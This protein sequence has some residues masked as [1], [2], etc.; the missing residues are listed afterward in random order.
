VSK[1]LFK[2]HVQSKMKAEVMQD[3]L[4][5]VN[6]DPAYT[7]TLLDQRA[8]GKKLALITNSDWIYTNT[9][10]TATYEPYL[11]HGMAWA[12]LFDVV[13][14]SACKPEFF[15]TSRRPVYEIA[16]ADGFLREGF[17]FTPGS[18][19]AGGNAKNV[20]RCLGVSGPEAL[21]VGD[22]LFTDVNMAKRGLSWRTCLILQELEGEMAGLGDGRPA[23][24]RLTRLLRKKD[25]Q[26][27]Y[28]NH[29]RA[30][31]LRLTP[32][33]KSDTSVTFS[34]SVSTVG[35]H[36]ALVDTDG[37]V[38]GGE[39]AAVAT[40]ALAAAV[41]AG[42]SEG[43][44]LHA[45]RSSLLEALKALEAEVAESESEILR[46]VDVEGNHV[47]A[48][49][50]YMSRAG[51]ADKSH[52]MR[53]IEKYADIYTS[54]VSNL[55]PYSPYKQFLCQRQSLAHSTTSY[56]GRPLMEHWQISALSE[57][58]ATTTLEGNESHDDAHESHDA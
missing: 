11:P 24:Q 35:G 21:Y 10:M 40:T 5:F 45:E 36:G 39:E 8:A 30:R 3:P 31:L 42:E 41:T 50:G 33:A 15:S 28:V 44:S 18:A 56:S 47:N 6:V 46:M 52:L 53:Q 51:F 34:P 57:I 25:L 37:G 7:R 26:A 12:D 9:M 4:R 55:M 49:W 48:Y 38:G 20:E 13:V 2:A 17:E 43:E 23:A 29:L 19:Y 27:A 54:R 32:A 1:A 14:V 22:H 16:T 58:E